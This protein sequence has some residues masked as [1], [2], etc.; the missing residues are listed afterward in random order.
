M[1]I[2]LLGLAIVHPSPIDLFRFL[3]YVLLFNLLP[4]FVVARFLFPRLSDLGLFVLYALCCGVL[5]N[6]LTFLPL[7]ILARTNFLLALPLLSVIVLF[8]CKR[9]FGH[10]LDGWVI[11][12]NDFASVAVAL[13]LVV[14]PLLTMGYFLRDGAIGSYSFH[15]GFES[16]VVASLAHGWP[17]QNL[18]LGDVPLSYHYAVHLWI[19]AA[20]EYTGIDIG[21]LASRLGPVFFCICACGIVFA[22]SRY[23]MKLPCWAAALLVVAIFWIVGVPP[24]SGAIFGTFTPYAAL[25]IMSPSFAFI[26]F[27]ILLTFV[28]NNLNNGGSQIGTAAL[29]IGLVSFAATGARAVAPPIFL[30]ALGLLWVVELWRGSRLVMKLSIFAIACALGFVAGLFFFF[31]LRTGVSGVGIVTITGQPFTFLVGPDQNVLTLPHLLMD[32][33]ISPLAA[34]IVAFAVMALFQAGFLV[35]GFFC[36][37]FA[38]KRSWT[39]TEIALLGTSIAGICAAFVTVAPGY[40]H[41]TF[42]QYSNIAMSMLGAHGLSRVVSLGKAEGFRGRKILVLATTGGLFVLQLGQLPLESLAWLGDHLGRTAS[43]LRPSQYGSPATQPLAQC[44]KGVDGSDL[45]SLV[46]K[47]SD[48][49]IVIIL[50]DKLDGDCESFWLTARYAIPTIGGYPLKYL[51]SQVRRD[52]LKLVYSDRAAAYVHARSEALAGRLPVSDL[53]KIASTVHRD[54]IVLALVGQGLSGDSGPSLF[55]VASNDRFVLLKI[56]RSPR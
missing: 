43:F 24:I 17:A 7:W 11:G 54:R 36:E 49:P 40:S 6:F 28:L 5:I 53:V 47:M 31:T 16:A 39:H 10:L 55:R 37:V 4:G 56:D 32:L 8:A 22:F 42:L 48:D 29:I 23:V 35:P 27:F 25:L 46:S 44:M 26:I 45:L 34:A 19:F 15:Y 2:P 38:F 51:G 20:H 52:D 41:L 1:I 33:R 3:F 18:L 30:C 9:R 12:K 13:L 50:S 14:T 21:V